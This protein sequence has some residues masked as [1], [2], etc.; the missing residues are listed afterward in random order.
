LRKNW[1]MR[2]TKQ[3]APKKGGSGGTLIIALV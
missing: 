2:S 3:R 1:V